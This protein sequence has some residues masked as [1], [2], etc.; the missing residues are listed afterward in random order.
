VGYRLL[1]ESSIRYIQN[2]AELNHHPLELFS[3][4]QF[5]IVDSDIKSLASLLLMKKHIRNP[6][7]GGWEKGN[8]RGSF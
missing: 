6:L 7:P 2:N 3:S 5:I 1:V 4:V 8:Q